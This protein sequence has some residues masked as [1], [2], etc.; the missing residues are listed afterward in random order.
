LFALAAVAPLAAQ[1]SRGA[2][3]GRVSDSSGGMIPGAN[4]TVTNTATN[5]ARRVTTNETGYYEANFLEPGPY[6]V[7]AESGGF[8]RYVRSGITVNV[9]TRLEINIT[10]EV[11]AVTEA[12][13]VTAEAPLLDTTSASG[14]RVLDQKNLINL[15]FSDLNPFALSALAPGMQWTGQPEYRR[16]FD[17]GGTSAFN[18]MGGVGQS[19]YTIDGMVVT[20][21][22]RR[23]GFIPPADSVTEFKLETTNFDASQGFTSGAAINVSSKS[24][25]NRFTGEIFNQHW[26]QRWNA[27][28]HFRRTQWEDN[29]RTGVY[30]PDVPKQATGRSNNY[31]ISL[32]GPVAIPKLFNG[33]DRFFWTFTWNGIRQTKA[34]TTGA[35][36]VTVPT[37]A[38]RQGDFSELWLAP[39][40]VR[41]FTIHDPRS[42]WLDRGV[43]RRTPFPGNRG[44]P[45]LNPMYQY[46]A[47]LYPEPNN[48]P[49]LVTPEGFNNYLAALMPKDEIF[50]S[51]VNRFDYIV[52]QRHRVNFRWQWNDR[53]ADEYDWTYATRRGLHSNGLTRINRGG[54]IN[55]LYTINSTNIL[56]AAFGISRFEEGARNDIR[57][58]IGPRDAG[59]PGYVHA[60]AGRFT[61][62]PQVD[63]NNIVDV[64]G[65]YPVVGAMGNTGELRAT[66]TS[67]RGNH[68]FKYGWQ[69]RRH[70][71]TALGPGHSGGNYQFR[72]PFVRSADNDNWSHN[73]GLDWAAFMMGVPNSVA[74]DTN[75]SFFFTTPRRALFIQDDWRVSTKLR[76]SLGIRYEMEGGI[77]ERFNR[78]I[79]GPFLAGLEQPFTAAV[80]AAYAANPIPELPA[81]QFNPVGGTAYLGTQGLDTATR[82][83]HVLL[84]K[85]G[86]V[87]NINNKTVIR[88]GYGAYMDSLNVNNTRPDTFGFNQATVTPVTNDFGLTFCCGIGGAGGLA[89]GRTVLD[90]PFPVRPDGTRFD[91]PMQRGLGGLPRVGRGFTSLPWEFRPAFQHRWRVGIQ[92]EIMRNTMVD[93]S[94]NGAYSTVPVNQRIDFLPR[95]QWSTGMVR[96]QANDDRLNRNVTNPFRIQN[97]TGLQQT[98]PALFNY[99]AGQPFFTAGVIRRHT[100][101]RPYGHMSGLNGLRPGLGI[102]QHWGYVDYHD[103]QVL[104]ERRMTR[105]FTSSLMY[106]GAYG[107]EAN[108][109]LNEF[110]DRPSERISNA[111]RP[112]RVAWT[113]IYELPFGKGRTHLKEGLGAWL[114]GNWNVSWVYQ[115]Q[116]GPA[117]DWGNQ[118]FYGDIDNIAGVFRSAETRAADM[119]QWFDSS[120]A[121]R[122]VGAIPQGFVGF[123]G[124][125]GQ[126]PGTFHE[127]VF[128][129]RL[130]QLRADGIRNWDVK[131][132]RFFPIVPER[133]IQ[134]RFSVDLLNATNRTNFNPPVVSPTDAN[135]GR[136][137]SQRG[138]PRVIQLNLRISF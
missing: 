43:V 84:P 111:L 44:V 108:F 135:F 117:T 72:N 15:P 127:R 50:D 7:A 27:T 37:M 35:V 49:G 8:R 52:N 61:V 69:E 55:W 130:E 16:P 33:K 120:I 110:D 32:S 39:E 75:D 131:I 62:L 93:V 133:G 54:N 115:A 20:G 76:L 138:L 125:A 71:W 21:T 47:A 109:Y 18:T 6:S 129:V 19:E 114:L 17:N 87:Y 4:V 89:Q 58:A 73:H 99:L 56:D 30:T 26:Q 41:R 90:D 11:G 106:T 25:N 132:E 94:Y 65:S 118:F 100:L 70:Q 68:T 98:D 137:T 126:T 67:I 60:R 59:L 23:V 83:T 34:E 22:N 48:V 2:V 38:M 14:G 104:I 123:E 96:D 45:V 103:V 40:G 64:S 77:R 1:E 31:G 95:N 5:E 136:V 85:L 57:T 63:F 97:L 82:G 86:I 80:R 119:R 81:A 124:R 116:S 3:T 28:G 51:L 13:E 92:R 24:G 53:L 36:N 122:G 79:A 78:G 107:R 29:V 113:A 42:A 102:G 112:H 66:M 134:A 121:F 91:E 46:Y 101:I 128:P 12:I 10:L 9:G 105:G 88:A 74:L